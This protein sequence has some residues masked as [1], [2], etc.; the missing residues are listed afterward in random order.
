MNNFYLRYIFI[1]I[2][3]VIAQAVIFNHLVLFNVA[4][5][6]IFVSLIV[7]LPVTTGTGLSTMLGFLTGFVIDI[8][9]DTPGVNALSCTVL[10]FMRKP[11]FHLYVSLDDDLAGRSPSGRSMGSP[12]FMKYLLTM[13]LIYCVLVFSIEAFQF[14]NLRLLILRILAST[15]YTFL[16]IYAFDS[17]TIRRREKKLQS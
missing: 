16:L 6:L 5:P 17:L 14:F 2:A 3:I 1:F 8:F 12:A 4:V 11:V 10:A 13:V 15:V 7:I 9:S